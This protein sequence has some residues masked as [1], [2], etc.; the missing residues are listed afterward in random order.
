MP[1]EKG[2]DMT[3]IE[4]EE[5]RRAREERMDRLLEEAREALRRSEE[6]TDRWRAEGIL[7]PRVPRRRF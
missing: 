7:P 2:D 6:I 3:E 1:T 4:R 5:A